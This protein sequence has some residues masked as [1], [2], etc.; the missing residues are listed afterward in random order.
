MISRFMTA[1]LF[2]RF[3]FAGSSVS[4]LSIYVP[5][6]DGSRAVATV[7]AEVFALRAAPWS[8]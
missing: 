7:L 3:P 1:L 4:A 6:P 2:L 5:R 8:A